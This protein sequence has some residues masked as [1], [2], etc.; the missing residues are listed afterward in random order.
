[1]TGREGDIEPERRHR[2]RLKKIKI[3]IPNDAYMFIEEHEG[4]DWSEVALNAIVRYARDLDLMDKL[5]GERFLTSDDVEEFEHRIK[6]CLA[7][8]GRVHA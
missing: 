2:D 7:R 6:D 5:A 3:V 4:V 1:M 8:Q